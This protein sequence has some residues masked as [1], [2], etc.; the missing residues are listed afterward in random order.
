MKLVAA[1]SFL[2]AAVHANIVGDDFTLLVKEG[3]ITGVVLKCPGKQTYYVVNN[4][5][6]SREIFKL[7]NEQL[8]D[9]EQ[10]GLI[11]DEY[12][13]MRATMGNELPTI[14]FAFDHA[15]NLK[16]QNKVLGTDFYVCRLM[17]PGIAILR[18][19]PDVGCD[20]VDIGRNAVAN[21]P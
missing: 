14:G 4:L 16:L 17:M 9:H 5:D 3:D 6:D 18:V 15:N 11:V 10:V 1:L 2:L 8:V 7:K 13:E 19:G 12:G 20:K 21:L